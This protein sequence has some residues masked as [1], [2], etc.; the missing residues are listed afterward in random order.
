MNT[1]SFGI[2]EQGEAV[3]QIHLHNA[4]LSCEIITY[5]ATLRTLLVP[6]KDGKPVDVVLG[7]D[8]L[9]QYASEDGYLGATVGRVANRIAK[10]SFTLNGQTYTL[11]LNDGNNHL[12][13]GLQGFSHR[14]WNIE[15]LADDSVTL[16]ITSPDG[17]QGYPGALKATAEYTLR[18]NAL[19][20]K[21]TA[22]SDKDTVCSLTNHSYF[23]LAGHNSGA[24]MGQ[25]IQLFASEY[26]PTDS[27]SIPLGTV[28]PVEGTP[29]NLQKMIPIKTHIDAP[30][31]QLEQAKGYDHNYVVSGSWGTL[32][33][34]ATVQ[35][36]LTGIAMQIDTTMP[37][38]QFYTGNY[39]NDGRAGKD[40]CEYGFR[41]GF[42]LETQHFPDAVNNDSFPAPLLKA[43]EI[44]QQET[45]FTF[46]AS[47]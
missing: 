38:I 23:N 30:F 2:T 7:Y 21:Y 14:V 5:G 34:A 26:T 32:R 31:L 41:H 13:G 47:K 36:D 45:V 24:A 33:P 42:C 10:G 39:L 19:I 44:Y 18:D 40:G 12:H 22:V 17:E 27:E 25:K 20:M 43:G 28:S 37:G 15:S 46:S 1:K 4:I 9:E 16:S 11:P 6:D 29:M 35:S 3:H 8:T